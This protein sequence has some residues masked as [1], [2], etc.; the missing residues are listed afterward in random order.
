MKVIKAVFL[1]VVLALV[2]ACANQPIEQQLTVAATVHA[3]TTRA[4]T[5]ALDAEAITSRDAGR[6]FELATNASEILNSARDLK[7]SDP[8]TAEGK[9]KLVDGILKELQDFLLQEL[10]EKANDAK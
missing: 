6:Y 8:S 5:A 4:V 10:K 1:T 9:V 2:T 7:D 3:S